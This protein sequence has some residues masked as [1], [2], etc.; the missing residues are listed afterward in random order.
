MPTTAEGVFIL[1]D[2]A[3]RPL[4]EIRNEAIKTDLALKK[5]GVTM[6]TIG[7]RG[8]IRQ[9][10]DLNRRMRGL[11]MAE[12]DVV[13]DTDRVDTRM[14]R[15]RRESDTLGT[16]IRKLG[17]TLM[18]LGKIINVL[19]FPA[20]AAGVGYA[21]QAV[22]A[23]AGGVV[24]LL[25]RI[26]DLGGA[27]APLP[28]LFT[29]MG[30]AMATVKLA[31]GDLSKA[32]GGNKQA[33]ERLT[34]AARNFLNTLK[35]Y[36]PVVQDLRTAAQEGLF[37]GLDFALRRMQ[38]AVPMAT[39][40]L[41]IYSRTLGGLAERGARAFTT[42]EFLRDFELLARQGAV[43]ID[44]M[45]TGVINLVRAFVAFGVAARPF[46]R[47]LLDTVVGWTEWIQG[48]T[49]A[50]RAS[51]RIG[52]YLDRT[53][54]SLTF[55][56]HLLRD[57]FFI[58]RDIGRA[59]R[60]LGDDLWE[61]FGKATRA[62][63]EWTG[64]I[65]G[66]IEMARGFAGMR[67]TIHELV[68]LV[69]DLGGALW[70]MSTEPGVAN[71][72]RT[73]R[74]A[75]GPLEQI[76]TTITQQF[77]PPLLAALGEAGRFLETL[78]GATG[79]LTI[80]L[81]LVTDILHAVNW[82]TDH[83]KGFGVALTAAISVI[84]VN[85]MIRRVQALAASWF[86]VARG[87]GVAAAAEA[88]ATGVAVGGPL[89]P[90]GRGG[91]GV[92]PGEVTTPGGVV[93]PP[94]VG[95][96]GPVPVPGGRLGRLG[97]RIGGMRGGAG[98]GALLT[99]LGGGLAARGGIGGMA[100]MGLRAAG[101]F[102][103]PAMAV[104]AAFDAATARREG[105]IGYQALQTGSA[106]LSGATFGLIPRVRTGTEQ[107][108]ERE[109]RMIE[110]YTR[111]RGTRPILGLAGRQ[112]ILGMLGQRG[113]RREHVA[114]IQ[115]QLTA[116]VGRFGGEDPRTRRQVVG[117]IGVYEAAIRRLNNAQSQGA[118]DY[119]AQLQAQVG[120]LRQVNTQLRQAEENQRRLEARRRGERSVTQAGRIATA[121]GRRFNVQARRQ[122]VEGAMLDTANVTVQ[123]MATLREPG[124]RALA[125][126]VI[127]WAREA[128]RQN[129]KLA[130]EYVKLQQKIQKQFE[131]MGQN[132]Q[133]VNG[134][135]LTNSRRDWNSIRETMVN[136][137]Q[138][139]RLGLENNFGAIRKL[140]VGQLQ[141]MGFSPAKAGAL[142]AA[143]NRGG[144]VG[145]TASTIVSRSAA[146]QAG[147]VRGEG[148]VYAATGARAT[149]GRLGG[150]GLS[151]SINLPTGDRAAPG[152]LV[153]NRHTERRIN[154]MLGGRTTL[155]QE[156]GRESRPHSASPRRFQTGGRMSQDAISQLAASVGFPNPGL[157]SAVAMAESGGNPMASNVNTNGTIDRGL[158]Q[159]NS[160]HGALSTFDIMGN[161]RAAYSISSGGSNWRP[162]VAYTTGRHRAYLGGGGGA[163]GGAAAAT[164]GVATGIG[165]IAQSIIGRFPGLVITST[166]G[167][168]H[169]K[170]SYHYRGM[171]VDIGGPGGL[172][173]AASDW[174]RQT[175]GNVLIEGI[176][177]PN[178]S[179]KNGQPV[180]P[181]FWGGG[182]WAG[183]ANHIHIAAGGGVAAV[184]MGAA[185]GVGMG[186]V[187]LTAPGVGVGGIGGVLAQAG[188]DMYAAGLQQRLND[189]IAFG[190]WHAGGM[191]TRRF[192]RPTLIGVG[193]GGAEDVTVTPV[194][195]GRGGLGGVSVS[196]GH[197]S[198][199]GPGD[200][201][202]VVEAE[203]TTALSRVAGKLESMGLEDDR[204]AMVG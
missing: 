198:Y 129:P 46:T 195:R 10:D 14:K 79:P 163:P 109:R 2:R 51:G 139:A 56:G 88:R 190:G 4:R 142:V 31:T 158:W 68:G 130:D 131:R 93:L 143:I 202:N 59:A 55:F 3:S 22:G 160:I 50:G 188:S 161:A 9:M 102:A 118:K 180:P 43:M 193:D 91:G 29:G 71:V 175:Y 162:W 30:L 145:A 183:H 12:R 178:L 140:A 44:R 204:A 52:R 84:G 110:G 6:D 1:I 127:S 115:E 23:L 48:A 114:G 15:V 27:V 189:Q 21:V 122:G 154:Y 16:S 7:S 97:G 123:A 26:A 171:A 176:H 95:R 151:D 125:Q 40:L 149:G 78:T 182:T 35:L 89:I 87:A 152:E 67:D 34:P 86:N 174:I 164:P 120:A 19:K 100:T 5:V 172:M 187:S 112:S 133:I 185:A 132:V 47:W 119:R 24:A 194:G 169:A 121:M 147:P 196:I 170:N 181:S 177:N 179:I 63:R 82:L 39:R 65:R 11:S 156:V 135:V 167:G 72:V 58:L 62:A 144:K 117:Q 200:I 111:E 184:P 148:A 38:R 201:A 106:V 186:N 36:K 61:S 25:P 138:L 69:A 45:G 134:K 18:S 108:E 32:Y 8:Q 101:R 199:N 137:A 155:G 168:T 85:I 74:G 75:V 166:T 90:G 76:L 53:R 28:A 153:V 192:N 54:Q 113:G 165:G 42:P 105:N 173:N 197:I 94:S 146:G 41:G 104:M 159:I 66:Q 128:S 77:G 99:R 126:N 37:G 33:L 73:L 57:T 203:I 96:G 81:N 116:G 13:R 49:E 83:I 150:S 107:M 157:A 80:M 92:R 64:S 141:A 103:L 60:P 70:R 17:A 124:R 20:L 98:A 136:Q 191:R